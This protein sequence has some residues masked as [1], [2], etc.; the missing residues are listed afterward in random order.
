MDKAL[1]LMQMNGAV[2]DCWDDAKTKQIQGK[3]TAATRFLVVGK[4]PDAKSEPDDV[5][6][7]TEIQKRANQYQT[8]TVTLKDLLRQMGW[9]APT[10]LVRYGVGANPVSSYAKPDKDLKSSNGAAPPPPFKPRTPPQP[11]A[12]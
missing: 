12:Y 7:F 10:Q 1:T 6:R 8:K 11:S 9:K 2:V 4:V 5:R 3:I